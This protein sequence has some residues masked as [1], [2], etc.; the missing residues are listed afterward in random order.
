MANNFLD[1]LRKGNIK[2]PTQLGFKNSQWDREWNN[3]NDC[4]E[5]SKNVYDAGKIIYSILSEIRD[6]LI[7]LYKRAPKIT[8]ENL[9]KLFFSFS[10]R[11]RFILNKNASIVYK[12]KKNI[13]SAKLAHNKI[14]ND[15][16]LMEIADG[17][18]DGIS[19]AIY[20]C[21][22]R[23]K[24]QQEITPGKEPLSVLK[25]I[26]TEV[27]LSQIYGACESY[28]Q[29]LVWADFK[30]IEN[31][32]KNKIYS[33]RR[34]KTEQEISY[35]I[36]QMRK[37]RLLAQ[38]NLTSLNPRIVGLFE[39]DKYL[40]IRKIGG[41]KSIRPVSISSC[42][43][44]TLKQLNT[45]WRVQEFLL[46]GFF[47]QEFISLE[48]N[49]GF[50]IK[51]VLNIFRCLM[52][53]SYQY[54]DSFPIDDSFKNINKLLM[55][56]PQINKIELT[57]GLANAT[58]L[59]FNRVS[60]ILN[61]IAFDN[62]PGKDLWCHPI[63]ALNKSNYI[64]LTSALS[65]PNII[66]IV[67]HWLTQAKIDL[68][69]K[70]ETY[71]KTVLGQINS[72]LSI[73][74]FLSDIS[75]FDYA[76]SKKF[77]VAGDEEQIDLIL[78]IG[79]YILIGEAKSIVT[80]DSPISQYR[81][82]STLK[83]AASQI[84]RKSVFVQNNLKSILKSAGWNYQ[85]DVDYIVISCI[86]NS[87]RV[88][89]GFKVDDVP[90]C[91]EKILSSYFTSNTIPLLSTIRSNKEF[92]LAWYTLYKNFEELKNNLYAYINNPPQIIGGINDFEYNVIK[93][94][95]LREN[96][97]KLIY[98]RFVFKDLPATKLL[99]KKGVF[100]IEVVDNIDQIIAN[101]NILI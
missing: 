71:E 55:F 34:E 63:I 10:N 60:K 21:I 61:F 65:A 25:F 92:H 101:P 89:A 88:Y 41:K 47:P 42:I 76:I 36:S 83:K 7:K 44:D 96:S 5:R 12:Y 29:A 70:G 45:D 13:F 18:V 73:N 94:P 54:S 72:A 64:I 6:E 53:L 14:N 43:S 52:L 17:C 91:D 86:I 90:V 15:L 2:Q 68:G 85:N 30:M 24:K 77:K 26:E 58:D 8:N 82:L 79:N 67:E 3:Y 23:I 84:K 19:K 4:D 51:E 31:C 57:K 75:D 40:S 9:L 81:T 100:S 66:R 99:D 38:S 11:D 50:S 74:T 20:S 80:S 27:Y 95:Y 87:G 62:E 78:R 22:C 35:E 28:W 98:E 1:E 49:R 69:D 37:Y 33:I 48:T 93:I 39:T 97:F 56:C 59:S 32:N 16:T 46:E